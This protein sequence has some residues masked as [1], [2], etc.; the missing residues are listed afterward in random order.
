[1]EIAERYGFSFFDA[2]IVALALRA[3][4]KILYS[5][6]LQHNQVIANRLQIRNPFALF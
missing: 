4:C 3:E 1:M 2:M 5:E 6:D